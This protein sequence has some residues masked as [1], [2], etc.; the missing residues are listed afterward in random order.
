M[1]DAKEQMAL[2]ELLTQLSKAELAVKRL[3]KM[4]G[5]V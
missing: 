2:A 3:E 1:L 5:D 4:A